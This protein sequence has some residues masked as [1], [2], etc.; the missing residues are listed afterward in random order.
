MSCPCIACKLDVMGERVRTCAYRF[1][2]F[3][4][5]LRSARE[6]LGEECQR[7]MISAGKGL[8]LIHI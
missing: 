5:G 7:S 3:V 1:S 4:L 2:V 8:S 6:I